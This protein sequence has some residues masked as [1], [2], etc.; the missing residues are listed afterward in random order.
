VIAYLDSSAIVKLVV[1]EPETKALWRA[2]ADWSERA[3]SRL[4]RVE[5]ARALAS[6]GDGAV[7]A[8]RAAIDALVLVPL[9]DVVLDGAA[10]LGPPTIRSLDALHVASALSLGDDLGVLVTYDERMRAAAEAVG[11][12]AIAPRLRTPAR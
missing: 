2:L 6:H 3:T 8:G 5:V 9:D 10:T 1:E 11:V 7:E 4:A 12:E